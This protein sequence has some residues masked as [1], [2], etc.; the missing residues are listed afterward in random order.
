MSQEYKT[1]SFLE[2]DLPEAAKA[3]SQVEQYA[4]SDPA[5]AG[6]KSRIA[7]ELLL[8]Q[9]FANERIEGIYN[10]TF[11]DM[12]YYLSSKG[13]IKRDIQLALDHIRRTGNKAVHSNEGLISEALNMHKD[14]YKIATW[15]YETYVTYAEPVA[16]YTEPKPS[17]QSSQSVDISLIVKALQESQGVPFINTHSTINNVQPD[18]KAVSESNTVEKEHAAVLEMDTDTKEVIEQNDTYLLSLK[19]QISRLK[20]SSKEAIE[21][22]NGLSEFK[23][24]LHIDRPIQNELLNYLKQ[25]EPPRLIL[26]SGGVGDG[27]SHMLAYLKSK[28]KKLI[29]N[30]FIHN[31]AT[32]S[33]SPEM[34][35]LETLEKVLA[36]YKD[37]EF[38]SNESQ[39][40]VAIN[41]GVLHNFVN[42]HSGSEFTIIRDFVQS[43]EIFTDKVVPWYSNE[44]NSIVMFNLSDSHSF[45]LSPIGPF[46]NFYE[47]LFA[48][49]F[50]KDQSNPFYNSFVNDIKNGK[51]TTAHENFEFLQS[52]HVQRQIINL[53]I[54][55]I[56]KDKL[57]ISTRTI[58]SFIADIVLGKDNSITGETLDDILPNILFSS[59]D[60]SELLNSISKL[61][62]LNKRSPLIDDLL[63]E[64]RLNN[65]WAS[66]YEK[67][68]TNDIAKKWMTKV[69]FT[70]EELLDETFKYKFIAMIRTAFLSTDEVIETNNIDSLGDHI[71]NSFMIDLYN[72]NSVKIPE[73]KKFYSD[74]KLIM[75]VWRGQPK[76]GFIIL[77]QSEKNFK[78]AQKFTPQPDY[79]AIESPLNNNKENLQYFKDNITLTYKNN[80]KGYITDMKLEIDYTLYNIL[81]RV[82]RGYRP[83]KRDEEIAVNFME[84]MD[85]MM[86]FGDRENELLIDFPGENKMY[87]LHAEGFGDIKE[88]IFERE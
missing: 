42:S 55:S 81:Y 29:S 58:L 41:L 49:V 35:A 62:P 54:Q 47:E 46:S 1:F 77:N 37:S 63:I 13:Y 43:S 70:D 11:N 59:S 52:I 10:P 44:D 24:Y 36:S 31:D 53:I 28:H 61:D 78:L 75:F 25:D 32:E 64:L 8:R 19:E 3:A 50:K 5:T 12:I 85:R 30:F 60:R 86:E 66:V 48:K 80:Q 7:A 4:F 51:K 69:S 9:V 17:P 20:D 38:K 67:V 71:F 74:F 72:F 14:L 79:G 76:K 84:F 88:I 6:A 65:N 82:N 68:I 34:S 15:Y 39:A 73:I 83:T 21:N 23:Q 87:K 33:F 56:V 26:L 27:K 18:I 2:K 40:I 22:S 45:E 57:V 16:P